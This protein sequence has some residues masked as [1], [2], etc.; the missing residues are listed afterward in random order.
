VDLPDP[1][2]GPGQIRVAVHAAGVNPTDWK[3]RKGLMGGE[4]PQTTGREVAG[5]VDEVG[6]G[7]TDVTAGDRVFGFSDDGAGRGRAGTALPLCAD[8]AVAWLRRGRRP[9]GRP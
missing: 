6:E 3:L 8:P 1:H 2:A 9:A 5:V 4:L 7:V